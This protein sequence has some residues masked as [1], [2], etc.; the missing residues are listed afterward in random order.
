M[1]I[2]EI[3]FK[4]DSPFLRELVRRQIEFTSTKTV[5]YKIV[6]PEDL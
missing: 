3:S 2:G 4:L 5:A 6:V 1:P